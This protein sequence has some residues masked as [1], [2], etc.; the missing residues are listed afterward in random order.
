MIGK[1]KGFTSI[2][3]VI[4]LFIVSMIIYIITFSM[5]NG[6]HLLNKTYKNKEILS[7]LEEEIEYERNKI[8]NSSSVTSYNKKKY[9][10]DYV[11][12]TVVKNTRF[13]DCYSLDLKVI[14]DLNTMEL[15]TYVRT[16]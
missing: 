2:E 7:L 11:V 15:K 9:L 5:H 12:E 14:S 13:L 6:F 4:S 10:G 3:C 16:K 1:K 8:K